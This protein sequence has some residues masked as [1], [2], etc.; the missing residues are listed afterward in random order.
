MTIQQFWS[1]Y[2][3]KIIENVPNA[4]ILINSMRSIGYDFESAVS[5]II[6]N[7]ITA[8]AKN[9]KLFFPIGGSSE[10]YLIIGDDGVG[11]SREEIIEAMRFGSIKNENRTRD[12][13]GR[14][15]LGLKTASISQCLQ[16]IVISKRD[17][18]LNGFSWDLDHLANTSRWEMIEL[19]KDS[20][21]NVP[22]INEYLDLPSFTLVYWNKFDRLNKDSYTNKTISDVFLEKIDN[23]KRQVSLIFHRFL[24]DR[25]QIL[26]NNRNVVPID[27]F[28]LKHSKTTTKPPQFINTKTSNGSDEKVE[29]Q[30]SI[31]PFHKDLNESDYEKLGGRDSFDDQ[32]FYV[33]R[34]KRLMIHGTWFKIKPRQ[35]LAS[36]ARIRVDIP[37]TLDDLWSIDVKKQ[38]AVL[39]GVLI[40]QLRYEVTDAIERSKKIHKN[41]AVAQTKEGSLWSKVYIRENSTIEYHINDEFELIASFMRDLEPKQVDDLKRIFKLIE[42]ALPYRDIYNSVADKTEIN[43]F[44]DKTKDYVLS[45]AL[46]LFKQYQSTKNIEPESLVDLICKVEPFLS[47]NIRE[48][49][50]EKIINGRK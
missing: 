15:G 32:G 31:L 13:L 42:L 19:T 16:L 21:L 28:L 49:L 1:F 25:L 23:T 38:K 20:I 7:S 36:N 5:D 40:E 14:F 26:F 43:D 18:S 10:P 37:N 50:M 30:V 11:M 2:M 45:S 8:L 34:N 46:K 6:D 17:N 48:Q 47:A 24:E 12:D 3:D 4:S 22:Q 27:P 9:I 39:P 33:Y 41:K 35:E 44:D 29:L